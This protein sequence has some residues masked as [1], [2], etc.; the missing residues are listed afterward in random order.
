MCRAKN[1]LCKPYRIG[2]VLGLAALLSAWTCTAVVNLN[3]CADAFPHSQI[4]ALSPNP[5]SAD[6]VSVV[7]SVEGTGFVSQSEIHWNK[8]PLP[9]TFIDSGHLQATVTQQTFDSFGGSAGNSVMISVVSP[10]TNSV[11]GCPNGGNSSTLI[12]DIN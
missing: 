9:T 2:L 5:I 6:I 10:G 7:L 1:V 4:G 8:N 3:G 12:L 11:V